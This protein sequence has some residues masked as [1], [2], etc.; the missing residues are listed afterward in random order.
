MF[1]STRMAMVMMSR[2]SDSKFKTTTTN[3]VECLFLGKNCPAYHFWTWPW[4]IEYREKCS[5]HTTDSVN[6]VA[7]LASYC[8]SSLM[9]F[10]SW[11]ELKFS[12]DLSL[13]RI[14]KPN[15]RQDKQHDIKMEINVF[16]YKLV[17]LALGTFMVV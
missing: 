7:R 17:K 12:L 1:S 14:M 5:W 2:H 15:H 10:I 16:F 9:C 6:I 3:C 11:Q 4:Q 13:W 8:F